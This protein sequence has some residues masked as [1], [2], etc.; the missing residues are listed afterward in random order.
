MP[1]QLGFKHVASFLADLAQLT[2]QAVLKG[3]LRVAAGFECE[4]APVE[5]LNQFVA[6][7]VTVLNQLLLGVQQLGEGRH[8][9]DAD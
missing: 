7:R 5:L 1:G 3:L 2:V 8:I 6:L 4:L 9:V